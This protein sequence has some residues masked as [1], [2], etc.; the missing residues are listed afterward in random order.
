MKKYEKQLAALAAMSNK[1]GGNP[2]YVL[3]GGGNTS[4][5]SEDLLWVKG[6][7]TALATIKAE[8]FVVLSRERL[9]AMWTVDYPVEEETRE[10][11]VLEDMMSARIE[12]ENRRPSVETLLHNLFPQQYILHVHPTIVNGLTC[13]KEGKTAAKQL[14]PQAVWVD[15]CK[16]G[17]IL[18]MECKKVMSAYK[19]ETGRDCDLM[20]LEN[21]GVFF[22][23]DTVEQLD[24]LAETV[25]STL[26]NTVKRNPDLNEVSVDEQKIAAVCDILS[27]LYGMDQQAY[28]K[29]LTNKE[30]LSYNPA[31]KSLSPDH[32]VY[33]KA[34]QL[35]VS[36]NADKDTI[37][38]L[39]DKFTAENGHKPKIVF[40]E[41]LGM[42]ACGMTEN[43]AT[44]ALTV[45]WDAI[46]VVAYT[47]S[48]GGV[49]PMP[50]FLID[51]IVNWEVESYRSKV[52]LDNQA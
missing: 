34:K 43:E 18:A 31:T 44:T 29:F 49:S 23:A 22:A 50:E 4:F 11:K 35:T 47:E 21:H 1:Y 41:N 40:V 37:V 20:F 33:A 9:D 16:P 30:I 19:Q 25:M 6:S 52:S 2:E 27:A 12:G 42:F 7:G 24:V 15:A 39:F 38:K 48:F 51:F 32:I 10:A 5:K 13:A 3:A 14:F 26:K 36:A 28:V 17:Y 46:K 45:M 8:D